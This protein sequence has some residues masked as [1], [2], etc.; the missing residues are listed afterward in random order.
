MHAGEKT[1]ASKKTTDLIVL[2][3]SVGR[4]TNRAADAG[5]N[6]LRFLVLRMLVTPCTEFLILNST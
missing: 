3:G 6:L 1:A 4:L 5:D 2:T